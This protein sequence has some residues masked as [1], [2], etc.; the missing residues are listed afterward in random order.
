MPSHPDL[1]DWLAVRFVEGGWDVKQLL[2]LIVTSATY[3]QSSVGTPAL[4]QRDPENRLLARGPR[5]RLPA[6]M[7]RDQALAVSGLLV[8]K[9]GGPPVKPFQPPGLWEAVSYNG[10]LS[11]QPDRDEGRWRR[12]VYSF[13]KRT[14]PPPGVQLLDG[15]TR[16]TCVV[17][18][19][20]TN[21]PLQALLLLN[22]ET[23]VEA[24][25]ALAASVLTRPGELR[26]GMDPVSGRD[27]GRAAE[28]FR[29]ATAR[30]PD[31][32][33]STALAGLFVRQRARFAADP[34]AARKLVNVGA[35]SRGHELA[36]VELAAWTVVAQTV[37]N[38]DEVV[39]R[40]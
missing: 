4:L 21:T 22:D 28:I 29:R 39:T 34:A 7:I 27:G 6:E 16:E 32:K 40:R 35:S 8:E 15:P 18:R 17:R 3:R 37:L 23:Y 26:S 2:R 11:Y 33:E 31:A 13:W 5:F 24:A 30:L 38:L 19:P 25:R 1:L 12:T 36:A 9:I 20:R 10:E 14:S